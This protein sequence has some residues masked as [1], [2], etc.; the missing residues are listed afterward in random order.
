MSNRLAYLVT[1]AAFA[2]GCGSA[3]PEAAAPSAAAAGPGLTGLLV[4]REASGL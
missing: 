4:S 2:A 3:E 1:L